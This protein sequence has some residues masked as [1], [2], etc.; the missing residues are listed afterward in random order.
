M[1]KILILFAVVILIGC[2]E[3]LIAQVPSQY[4]HVDASCGAALPD[5]LPKLIFSDNCEIDTVWQSPTAGTW[6]TEPT[7]TVLVR[8]IDK[9][10]NY[11]DMMFTVTLIDTVPPTIT[12]GDSTLIAEVYEQISSM[13]DVADRM[14]ARQEM[15][16]DSNFDYDAYGVPDTI[17]PIQEY[18][19]KTLVT[20]T[21]PA[22]AFTGVGQRWHTFVNENDSLYITRR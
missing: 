2:D 6:L 11:T 22:L 1:K 12:I 10:N 16:F 5:Y 8:A 4:L 9:F 15:W 7:T 19:N 14:L 20:W 3:C 21:S 17:Q 18:A 13:Y